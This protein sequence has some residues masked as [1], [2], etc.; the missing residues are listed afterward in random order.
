MIESIIETPVLDKTKILLEEYAQAL[1][2]ENALVMANQISQDEW[3]RLITK[4]AV[5]ATN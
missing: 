1:G 5:K 2:Y 4:I 3:T